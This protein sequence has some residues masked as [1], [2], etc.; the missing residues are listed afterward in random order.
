MVAYSFQK[1][2]A[3]PIL[4]GRKLGTIRAPRKRHA[5]PGETMHLFT[6]MRTKHCRL[7]AEKTCHIA[8]AVELNFHR[9]FGPGVWKVA[10][11]ELNAATMNCLAREDGFADVLD[12]TAF[13][14]DQHGREATEI[15][16]EGV[17]LRWG[18]LLR[19]ER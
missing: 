13:W 14:F 2:F 12:M 18:G 1:R 9:Q 4:E 6:G 5:R 15:K 7:I 17:L 16:F 11:I 19:W 10:G 3:E 8:C